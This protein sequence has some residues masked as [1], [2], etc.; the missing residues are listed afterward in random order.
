MRQSLWRR[1][2]WALFLAGP[3][4]LLRR[5]PIVGDVVDAWPTAEARAQPPASSPSGPTFWRWGN[6]G[7]VGLFFLC[8]MSPAL[9]GIV[10]HG[11]HRP[12]VPAPPPSSSLVEPVRFAPPVPPPQ[13]PCRPAAS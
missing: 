12:A 7:A 11:P 1:I 4:L 13:P 3:R 2:L 8:L 5:V 9:V 10:V 6:P